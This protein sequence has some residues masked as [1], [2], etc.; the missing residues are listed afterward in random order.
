MLL[1]QGWQADRAQ[2]VRR[3]KCA[4][5]R[6][7]TRLATKRHAAGGLNNRIKC[8]Y[9]TCYGAA[10]GPLP[11]RLNDVRACHGHDHGEPSSRLSFLLRALR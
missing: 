7:P 5:G 2:A 8:N 6:Q 1:E 11:P 10:C 3:T 9:V 4:N